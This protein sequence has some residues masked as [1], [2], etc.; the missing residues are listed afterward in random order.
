MLQT[1]KKTHFM[2]A[3]KR[4]LILL[5]VHSLLL[6]ASGQSLS[7]Y[8]F[9]ELV[10]INVLQIYSH[11]ADN[12]SINKQDNWM[13]WEGSAKLIVEKENKKH[14]SIEQI[15]EP[16]NLKTLGKVKYNKIDF[17]Y[18]NNTQ[19]IIFKSEKRSYAKIEDFGNQKRTECPEYGCSNELNILQYIE[20]IRSSKYYNC[21]QNVCV[22]QSNNRNLATITQSS[23]LSISSIL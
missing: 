3:S 1:I 10:N 4:V 19:S 22:Q 21:L 7:N 12:I 9:I 2:G 14:T 5:F 23:F 8:E 13:V 15:K 18:R 20:A 16:D 6:S 11:V 17:K